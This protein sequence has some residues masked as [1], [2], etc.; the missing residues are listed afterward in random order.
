M[1][2]LW[3]SQQWQQLQ[4]RLG[5]QAYF[6]EDTLVIEKP[7][8]GR[9]RYAEV[10]RA[11]PPVS[12]WEAIQTKNYVFL[13]FAPAQETAE[14]PKQLQIKPSHPAHFPTVTRVLDLTKSEEEML[15][16][17]SQQC[18]RHIRKAERAGVSVE[19]SQDT[20]SFAHLSAETAKRDGFAC[21]PASYYETFLDTFGDRAELL[22]AKKD[23]RVLAGLILI[24]WGEVAYYYYGA[25][26]VP[27]DN[28]PTLLQWEAMRRAKERGAKVYDLLGVAEDEEDTKEELHRVSQFKR[29]FG[30]ERVLLGKEQFVIFRPLLFWLF[31][32][33]KRLR[34]LFRK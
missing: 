33:L 8:R 12:F 14:V 31:F 26:T 29:K 22:V 11:D 24:F 16:S 4:E 30:G 19:G 9:Y 20:R 6:L 21:H 17:F 2:F 25:S 27:N 13:R 32:S 15:A 3:Q 7:L 23:G 18:R 5:R 1:K 28:A 34:S 10:L